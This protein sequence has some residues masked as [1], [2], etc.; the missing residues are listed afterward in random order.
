MWR[1]GFLAAG[2]DLDVGI[3]PNTAVLFMDVAECNKIGP[4]PGPLPQVSLYEFHSSLSKKAISKTSRRKHEPAEGSHT[5]KA[6]LT[7][8]GGD[9][10][11]RCVRPRCWLQ[12]PTR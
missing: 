6:S 3:C 9:P 11:C 2:N 4:G 5:E 12:C 10:G 7:L 8:L 1:K